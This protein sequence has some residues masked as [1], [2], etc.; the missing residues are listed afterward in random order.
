MKKLLLIGLLF[1]GAASAETVN[2]DC[3]YSFDGHEY[4]ALIQYNSAPA[5]LIINGELHNQPR[6][7]ILKHKMRFQMFEDTVIIR[8]T[9]TGKL[10]ANSNQIKNL[11]CE[12]YGA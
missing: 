5:R 6:A 3:D 9:F 7:T 1:A 12:I 10:I 2:Y 4:S 11:Q 8:D